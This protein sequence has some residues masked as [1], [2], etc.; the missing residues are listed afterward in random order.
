MSDKSWRIALFGF[1]SVPGI[2]LLKIAAIICGLKIAYGQMPPPKD[3][4]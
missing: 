3:A 1:L 4:E 2:L